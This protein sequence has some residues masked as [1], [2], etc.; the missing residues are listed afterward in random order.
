MLNMIDGFRV[1][2]ENSY[3]L[4]VVLLLSGSSSTHD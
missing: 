3:L 1:L 4:T 2:I